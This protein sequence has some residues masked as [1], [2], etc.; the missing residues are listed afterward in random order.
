MNP[1]RGDCV[2]PRASGSELRVKDRDRDRAG[3]RDGVGEADEIRGE[4]GDSPG[5]AID[6]VGA[7]SSKAK[8]CSA[9]MRSTR[10]RHISFDNSMPKIRIGF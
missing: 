4:G 10:I 8:T 2:P 9:R 1:C 5:S 7:V 3:D 6:S